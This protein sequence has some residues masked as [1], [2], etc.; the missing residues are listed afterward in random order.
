MDD[1]SI[2]NMV[3]TKTSGVLTAAATYGVFAVF[4][5]LTR[6]AL[7]LE[8][9]ENLWAEAARHAFVAFPIVTLAGWAASS[10][11]N[12]D[13]AWAFFPFAVTLAFGIMAANIARAVA[14]KGAEEVIN[15]I[16]KHFGYKKDK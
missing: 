16:F 7:G 14:T 4:G 12:D 1:G 13:P 9:K 2:V 6:V 8:E 15:S 3:A 10:W 11:V 5:G